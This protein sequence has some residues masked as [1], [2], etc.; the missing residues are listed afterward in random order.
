[1]HPEKARTSEPSG[2][3]KNEAVP[4]FT[5]IE[6]LVV[7]A[8]I[9]I[10]AAMLLP[11][12]AKAQE[13]AKRITC[14]NN[15]K[16]LMLVSMM[17]SDDDSKGA[18][19]NTA[20]D[21]DDDASWVYDNSYI[22]NVNTFVCPSTQNFIRTNLYRNLTTGQI[23]LYD[24]TYAA[25]CKLQLP[26]TS[27]EIFAFWGYS[28]YGPTGPYPSARKTRTNVQTWQYHWKSSLYP[29]CNA[30]IGTVGGPS[31]ACMF[32]DGDSGYAGTRNNIPDAVDNHG[33]AGGNVSF[34]DGHAEFV[35]ARPESKYIQM[36]YLATDADP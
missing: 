34:C 28:G 12:L 18:F 24:L 21:G 8:I 17:Y 31:R 30:F 26:G 36:I 32:L 4:G 33:A 9:A 35:S 6:L 20:N 22:R 11:A 1:M 2:V 16:Q 19:A 3:L 14:L 25:G 29:Y 23:S 10:L 7:I 15:E 27:Y 13:R 5:L